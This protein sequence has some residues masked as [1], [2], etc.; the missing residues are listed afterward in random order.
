MQYCP[1][2]APVTV[3]AFR[4]ADELVI[5]VADAGLGLP[6]G[7]IERIL[8]RSIALLMPAE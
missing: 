3:K 5:T 8:T 6:K 1:P 7:D 2:G 4:S